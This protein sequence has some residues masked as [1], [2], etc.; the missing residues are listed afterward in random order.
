[1]MTSYF[2]LLKYA[3]TGQASPDMTYYDRMRASTLMGGVVQTLTGQPPLT[4]KADGSPLIS[5]SMIGNGSQQGTPTP[6]APIMPTFCGVRTGNIA[7]LWNIDATFLN[8]RYTTGSAMTISI[9]GTKAE[10]INVHSI[11]TPNIILPAGK[12]TVKIK[13]IGGTITGISDGVFFGINRNTYGQRTTPGVKVVGEV[14]TRTFTLSDDTLITSLDITPGYGNSGSVFTD[15]TFECGLYAG[16]SA[17]ADYEPYGYKIPISCGGE[18]TP[19][20][21]GQT[22]TVRRVKKLVLNGT[23]EWESVGGDSKYYRLVIGELNYAVGNSGI[24]THYELAYVTSSTYNVGFCIANPISLSKSCLNIRPENVSST[25]VNSFKQFLADEYAAGHPVTV[26]YV[27]AEPETAIVNG[28]LAKIGDY[29]DELHS[30]DAAVT[31]PTVKGQNTLTV[32][33][34]IQPSEMAITFKG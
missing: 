31:I 20:Y 25:T 32:D 10:G 23:E 11:A 19:V 28:P 22:Q 15:A 3:A 24:C 26:W 1:M 18:I 4:F 21:L 6:D 16:S 14:G 5:W 12:Y 2:N 30:T 29:A 13:M 33:T 7:N 8:L 17:P 9:N 27:L 34:P